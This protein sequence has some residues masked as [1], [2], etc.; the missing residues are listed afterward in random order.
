ML[1]YKEEYRIEKSGERM[2]QKGFENVL[3]TNICN[4][5]HRSLRRTLVLK[6]SDW[7]GF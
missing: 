1:C 6:I 4:T 7:A 2:E 5:V 3:L